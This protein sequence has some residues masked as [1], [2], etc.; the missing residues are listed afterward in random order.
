MK[1]DRIKSV[2]LKF[3]Q[4]TLDSCGDQNACT[5]VQTGGTLENNNKVVR[6]CARLSKQSEKRVTMPS[7]FQ[8]ALAC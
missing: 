1:P 7:W 8:S 6:F 5:C 2:S 4:G 3:N